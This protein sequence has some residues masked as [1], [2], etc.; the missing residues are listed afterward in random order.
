MSHYYSVGGRV[1][2][3]E[4]T[5]EALIREIR[6]ELDLEL[7]IKDLAIVQE[8]FYTLPHNEEKIHEILKETRIENRIQSPGL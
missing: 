8:S 1:R 3:G 6:E 5:R 4:S 7:K 2:F